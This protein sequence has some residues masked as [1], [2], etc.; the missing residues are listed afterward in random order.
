M[1]PRKH[2]K[3]IAGIIKYEYIKYDNTGE[4]DAE[5]KQ[6]ITNIALNIANHFERA[7]SWFNKTIFLMACEFEE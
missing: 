5:G 6:A 1:T 3:A 7:N 4:D 2:Y